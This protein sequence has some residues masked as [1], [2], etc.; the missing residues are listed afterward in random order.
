[1]QEIK[2]AVARMLDERH[3]LEFGENAGV[4]SPSAYWTDFCSF[5]DYVPGMQDEAFAKLRLHT[6]HLTGD[7]YL[8]YYMDTGRGESRFLAAWRRQV[9]GVPENYILYEPGQGI[10]YRT[11]GG[12]VSVDITRYQHVV[13]T[14][15]RQGIFDGLRGRRPFL[16]EIGSGYG[17]LA[18]HLSRV[19][20]ASTVVLVD[21]P[22]TL[23]FAAVY[24]TLNN[25]D[26]RVWVYTPDRVE[27]LSRPEVLAEYDFV[28]LPNYRLDALSELEF[29]LVLNMASLQEMRTEQVI[30]YLDF[31]SGTCRGVFYSWNRESANPVNRELQSLT[32]L[33]EERFDVEDVTATAPVPRLGAKARIKASLKGLAIQTGM[34]ERPLADPSGRKRELLC[35]PRKA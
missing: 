19:I 30:E 8:T 34:M 27:E 9:E 14:L 2:A 32:T 4:V 35:R 12:L 26:K 29:D 7:N 22:E 17:G 1:V 21:L 23:L 13:N 28:C 10:G 33:V 11:P 6:Y 5:F 18:H 24:V 31:I 25:P 15:H 20:G 16:L 3:Q